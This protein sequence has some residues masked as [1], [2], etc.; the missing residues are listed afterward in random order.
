MTTGNLALNLLWV[1]VGVSICIESVYLG[2]FSPTGPGTGL[3]P[4]IAGLAIAICGGLMALPILMKSSNRKVNLSF[5]Q[6][7]GAWK[8]VT[9]VVVACCGMTLLIPYLGFLL[10]SIPVMT[11]LCFLLN[12]GKWINGV[13][14]PLFCIIIYF[15]FTYVLGTQLPR[16]ILSL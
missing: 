2:L 12:P 9:S 5:W 11:F 14:V 10:I 3:L 1:L 16:G 6:H 8:A 15:L 7:R 4:F 13:T